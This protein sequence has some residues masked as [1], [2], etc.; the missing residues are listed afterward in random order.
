MILIIFKNHSNLEGT[1]APFPASKSSWLRYSDEKIIE[2]KNNMKAK[3]MGTRLHEWAA[4]TI[5]LGIKMPRTK[6]TIN[7]YINDAIGFNMSPEVV[8]YY[9]PYFYG[10]ADTI[11][12]NQ[13]TK[14]LRIHDL[15]TGV[16]PAHMEQLIVYAALFCLE[17][18]VNPR[19]LTKIDLAIY[20]CDEVISYN[21]TP[22]EILDVMN[23]IIH[24]DNILRE[25]EN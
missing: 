8:L 21:P 20:Q 5:K 15:K 24:F 4:E 9:S 19:E 16:V 23:T 18:K 1:H 6:R 3:E 14:V 17:Y 7:A 12:Y 2:Y 11:Y 10:T 22:E 25:D 13:K